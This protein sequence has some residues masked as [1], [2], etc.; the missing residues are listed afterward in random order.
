MGR[1]SAQ[2]A[3][4]EGTAAMQVIDGRSV[5]SLSGLRIDVVCPSD[6][7]VFA[8]IPASAEADVDRAVRAARHA[9]DS[10]PWSRMTALERGR[11]LTAFS[12]LLSD[13]ISLNVERRHLDESQRAMIADRL[14][15]MPQ[16]RPAENAQ[17]CAFS[18]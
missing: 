15:T 12:G 17:I 7:K 11:L 4:A 14:A 18:Q 10:R 13:V 16:G 3:T 9:F 2:R 5:D 1:H 8:S 6:G